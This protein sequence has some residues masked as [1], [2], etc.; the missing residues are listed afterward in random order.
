MQKQSNVADGVGDEM[1]TAQRH[2]SPLNWLLL[3]SEADAADAGRICKW[4][5]RSCMIEEYIRALKSGA[6][7]EDRRFNDADDLL[8][9]LD[10]D[11]VEML[12]WS[13]SSQFNLQF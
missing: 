7:C 4:H 9:R 11:A 8:K 6:R 5:E 13:I 10:F 2:K 1:F 3:C 12:D